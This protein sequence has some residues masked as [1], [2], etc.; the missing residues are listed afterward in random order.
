MDINLDIHPKPFTEHLEVQY[1]P[2]EI[3]SDGEANVNE[4][5]NNYTVSEN[6]HLTNSLRGFP[7]DGIEFQVPSNLKGLVFQE[8]LNTSD[9]NCGKLF[10]VAGTFDNFTYWNY[11]KVPSAADGL[12]QA[13]EVLAVADELNKPLSAKDIQNEIDHKL[14]IKKEES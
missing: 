12:R 10:R 5:F 4:Y 3:E 1:F 14:S 7:L 11:D 2:A 9:E 8:S 6:G 13:F